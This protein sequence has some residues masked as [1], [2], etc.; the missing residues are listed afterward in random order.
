MERS[1]VR[2]TLLYEWKEARDTARRSG[3]EHGMAA[4][5]NSFEEA[6][7]LAANPV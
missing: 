5:F 6:L 7:S 3:M 2:I 4:S 1:R